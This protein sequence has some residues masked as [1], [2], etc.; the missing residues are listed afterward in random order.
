MPRSSKRACGLDNST[1]KRRMLCSALEREVVRL[2]SCSPAKDAEYFSTQ[3]YSLPCTPI[4]SEV[5]RTPGRSLL[6]ADNFSESRSRNSGGAWFQGKAEIQPT[7]A[8]SSSSVL[9]L[10]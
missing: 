2:C 8:C 10:S 3:R 4:G 6:Q 5:A 9:A 1:D 7:P